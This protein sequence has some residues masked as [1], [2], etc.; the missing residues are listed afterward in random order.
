M[1]LSTE[2]LEVINHFIKGENIFLTGPGGTGKTFLI[3]EI[4]DI[5][6]KNDKNIQ[7]CAMTGC[8]SVLLNCENTKTLHSWSGIGL[9]NG[10][11][12]DIIERII[13]NY[14][15]RKT[16]KKVDVLVVDEVSM[17]SKK[18]FDL[19]NS[20]GKRIRREYTKPFGGIQIVFSG[21]FYQ[22][23]PVGNEDDPDTTSFCFE[24]TEWHTVFNKNINLTKIFRQKDDVYCKILNQIRI[25]KLTRT[26]YQRLNERI[27]KYEVKQDNAIIPTILMPKR[28]DVDLI[29]QREIKKLEGETKIYNLSRHDD[30]EVTNKKDDSMYF[31]REQYDNEWRHLENNIIAE[32]A[33]EL[34]IGTQVMC[35]A[36]IDVDGPNPIVNG[37]Q[38][39]VVSFVNDLPMVKFNDNH[40]RVIGK[41]TWISENCKKVGV[42]QIPLIHAWAI[43]IHKAQG[44]TLDLV[45]LDAGNSI[46]E[47]GQTYVALSRV[48]SLSGLYLKAFN[49]QKIKIYKKVQDFYKSI[50]K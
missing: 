48:K 45:E 28:R 23:P 15:R 26:S 47:C 34:K 37:S 2:Q 8:A 22:L 10:P 24:S 50:M 42:R 6:K 1:E 11:I 18:I 20:L 30:L 31:P 39:I 27:V 25:G 3:K 33:L 13:K 9:A 49:P 40:T 5:A 12:E 17:M 38:G 29:N 41:H 43:T 16:W 4:Y 44:A 14:F 46:F 32:K 35:V 36:N 21:D 19:L 7:I